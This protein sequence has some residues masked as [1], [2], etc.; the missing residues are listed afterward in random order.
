VEWGVQIHRAVSP[1]E[2][3]L[4]GRAGVQRLTVP[5]PWAW[6]ERKRGVWDL[7]SVDHFLEPVRDSAL[8][9]QG[10]LGPGISERW[11]PWVVESGGADAADYT[12]WFV[13][14]CRE[15]VQRCPDI[16]VF[17]VEE[18]LNSAFWWDGL[19][20]RR[21]VGRLWR[22]PSFRRLL[23]ERCCAAIWE[24]RPEVELRVTFRPG[25]PGWKRDLSRLARTGLPIARLGL[26]LPASSIFADPELGAD[27]GAWIQEARAILDSS[28]GNEMQVEVAR[29][30]YPTHR[31]R[32][33]PR[34]QR[35]FLAHAANAAA[36]ARSAGFH[37]WALRDQAHDDPI[38]GY[39]TPDSERHMGLLY[40]DSTPK[41][42]MDEFRVLA[43]GDRFGEGGG[44]VTS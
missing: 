28:G 13:D 39:W 27:V 22:D 40:Y 29:C 3:Q 35:E 25:I 9:L 15:M 44:A 5:L 17:R 41:P 37:W 20:T 42:S 30:G 16:S 24:V 23:L 38:L 7:A 26:S 14:Y 34:A 6:A 18:D 11:P 33:S 43:T 21:R 4:L 32:Y 8:A 12:E 31:S 36:A 10:V 1:A 2:V 19:R